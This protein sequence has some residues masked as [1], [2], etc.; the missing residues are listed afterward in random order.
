[1][2]KVS[3]STIEAVGYDGE[4][5]TMTVHFKNG[6]KYKYHDVPE[7]AYNELLAADSVGKHLHKHVRGKFAYSKIEEERKP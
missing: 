2:K 7:A 3:S 4:T 6:G 5:K 1:M